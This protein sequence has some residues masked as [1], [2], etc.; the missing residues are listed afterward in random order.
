MK[1]GMDIGGST[2]RIA[3]VKG[4]RTLFHSKEYPANINSNRFVLKEIGE[5]I[6]KLATEEVEIIGCAVAG[7]MEERTKN[8]FKNVLSRFS[9]N[10]FIFPDIS[11]AYFAVFGHGNGILALSGTGSVVYGKHG[12]KE[13]VIGGLGYILGDEGSGFWIGKEFLKNALYEMQKGEKGTYANLAKEYFLKDNVHAII[14]K[15]YDE[16]P[17]STLS[18]FGKFAM[19]KISSDEIINLGAKILAED[20][21]TAA[22]LLNFRNEVPVS[23]SGGVFSHSEYF[24]NKFFSYFGKT[25]EYKVQEA[26]YPTEIAAIKLA[27][28]KN[29]E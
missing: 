2:I 10:V 3:I 5:E 4:D 21:I 28:E 18:K 23:V 20:A 14:E 9:K 6:S 29:A 16:N 22:K 26:N 13:A 17:Q 11:V 24:Y 8:L 15:I 19:E 1:I 7:G 25:F 12:E 27:E